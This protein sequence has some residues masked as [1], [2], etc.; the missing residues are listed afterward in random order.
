M[1]EAAPIELLSLTPDPLREVLGEHFAARGQPR[2]RA[3][4]VE[5]WIFEGLAPS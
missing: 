1:S 5:R 2:Y 4:Q 3:G